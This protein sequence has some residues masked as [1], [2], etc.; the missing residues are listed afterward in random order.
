MILCIQLNDCL[1]QTDTNTT[2]Q[3]HIGLQVN[4][5]ASTSNCIFPYVYVFFQE[6]TG[7]A[8][9]NSAAGSTCQGDGEQTGGAQTTYESGE[10]GEGVSK[11]GW[12]GTAC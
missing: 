11:M 2:S 9:G 4:M 10:R 3:G 7:I 5:Q 8:Y 6:S 1:K 12:G